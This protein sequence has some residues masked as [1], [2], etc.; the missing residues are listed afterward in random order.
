MNHEFVAAIEI[1][2]SGRIHVSP[3]KS[4]FPYIYREAVEVSW[5]ESTQTLHSPVPREWGYARW[6]RQ[7]FAAAAE[8]GTQLELSPQTRWINVPP[9]LQADLASAV[10]TA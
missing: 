9:D 5:D 7:I 6:L 3:S 8:Q 2:A 10:H 1:D 4:H